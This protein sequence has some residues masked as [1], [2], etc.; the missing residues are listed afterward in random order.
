VKKSYEKNVLKRVN[1]KKLEKQNVILKIITNNALVK[2]TT[3]T[4]HAKIRHFYQKVSSITVIRN[5]CKFTDRNRGVLGSLGVS[6]L[7]FKSVSSG[8]LMSGVKK[9][10]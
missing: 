5:T 10:S 9:S 2:N 8:G 4:K 3:R 1:F 6:R 7:L